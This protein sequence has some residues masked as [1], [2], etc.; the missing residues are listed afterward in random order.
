MLRFVTGEVTQR[1]T[2]ALG[3]HSELGQGGGG[4]VALDLAD[5]AFGCEASRQLFLGEP[6]S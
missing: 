3:H 4:A 2:K 1:E 5:E 6:A